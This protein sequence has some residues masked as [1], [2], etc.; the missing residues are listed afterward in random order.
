[1]HQ[2]QMNWRAFIISEI[3]DKLKNTYSFYHTQLSDYNDTK[4]SSIIKRF[5]YMAKDFI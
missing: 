1:M 5:D 3:Q 4:L 2:F